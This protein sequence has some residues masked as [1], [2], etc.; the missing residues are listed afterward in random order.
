MPCHDDQDAESAKRVDPDDP[1]ARIGQR[2]DGL[3]FGPAGGFEGR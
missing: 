1:R 2:L 3:R